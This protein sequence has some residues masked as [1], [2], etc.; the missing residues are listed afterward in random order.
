[1]CDVHV[2]RYAAYLLISSCTLSV[3]TPMPRRACRRCASMTSPRL[4]AFELADSCAMLT[5]LPSSSCQQH[6]HN[7]NTIGFQRH[8]H[9]HTHTQSQW[10][11]LSSALAL[12]ALP[13]ALRPPCALPLA[14]PHSPAARPL[15]PTC[16][17][18]LLPVDRVIH[19]Q[20]AVILT[21]TPSR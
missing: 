17:V 19:I 16:L 2:C 7:R 6:L 12:C 21:P 14:A 9:T 20:R 1:M 5:E 10:P 11:P 3:R 13:S 4:R 15:C 18:R 8:T